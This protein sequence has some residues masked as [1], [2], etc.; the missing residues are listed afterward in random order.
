M[1]LEQMKQEEVALAGPVTAAAVILP[2]DFGN[3]MLNDSKKLSEKHR[4]LLRPLI[5]NK[6]V[7]YKVAHLNPEVI[8]KINILNAS[9]AAMH[10]ALNGLSTTPN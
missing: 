9:I 5:E 7:T 1:K 3:T 6:A 4:E 8:D 2:Q 10:K